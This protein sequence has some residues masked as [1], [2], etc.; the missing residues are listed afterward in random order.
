MAHEEEAG[1]L[2]GW[3][4]VVGFSTGICITILLASKTGVCSAKTAVCVFMFCVDSPEKSLGL[5][6][7]L[8]PAKAMDL[9][10]HKIVHAHMLCLAV[11]TSCIQGISSPAR[12]SRAFVTLNGFRR[13]TISRQIRRPPLSLQANT[14]KM[15]LEIHRVRRSWL[16]DYLDDVWTHVFHSFPR[17]ALYAFPAALG[18]L[19]LLCCATVLMD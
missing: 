16:S 9:T 15:G 5:T 11:C 18:I 10:R 19:F 4:L 1:L 12:I 17:S 2:Q 14:K 13:R 6:E 7:S 8:Q 3:T